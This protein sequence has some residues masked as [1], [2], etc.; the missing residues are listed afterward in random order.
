MS[1]SFNHDFW[2]PPTTPTN[3]STAAPLP[4][5]SG[6]VS[7]TLP[8]PVRS[9][10]NALLA[11]SLAQKL[12]PTNGQAHCYE[13]TLE[14]PDSLVLHVIG[15]QGQGLKQAHNLSSS[16]LAAF[17][18]GSAENEGRQ[19]VTIRGTNQQIGKALMQK[20]GNA[21]LGVAAPAPSP[22]NLG[23]ISSIPRPPTQQTQPPPT[24]TLSHPAT[25]SAT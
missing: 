11:I 15:H 9:T 1:T 8:I 10:S 17:A 13:C 22:S 19:F 3:T 18:V 14:I 16:W 2:S 23:F 25:T 7:G 5:T 20:T 4:S 21:A 12:P 6:Q 24:P